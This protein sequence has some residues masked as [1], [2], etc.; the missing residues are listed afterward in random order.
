MKHIPLGSS[1][2][3]VSELCIGSMTWGRQNIQEE[4]FAQ[5]DR[6][7]DYGINFVDTAEMYPVMPIEAETVGGSEEII[8]NWCAKTGRRKDLVI[9]TKITGPNGGFVR[10]GKGIFPET[11]RA[12]VE[13]SLARLQSD[14]IDLYQ[15]HWPN[16]GSYHF[17]QH[18]NYDPSKQDV[19]GELQNIADLAGVLTEL[20]DAGKIRAFGLSND[21]SW[22]TMQWVKA[23]DAAGGPR[24]VTMQNEYS[25]LCRYFDTDMGEICHHEDITLIAYS[26]LATGLLTGKY[27][28]GA[29]PEGS[30]MSRVKNLSGRSTER[31][32]AATKAYKNIADKHGISLIHLALAFVRA[33]PFRAIPI[34]GATSLEQLEAVFGAEDVEMTDEIM[35]E[36]NDVHRQYPLPY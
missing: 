19:S 10:D 7:T 14:Y 25:L 30:R 32:H 24:P 33:R 22:G 12:A 8:G 5:L 29:V 21:T 18:W 1:D 3:H 6:A 20:R 16:R 13:A 36:I 26:P 17:R 15:F 31:S 23:S 35:G 27:M 34:F 11:V 2:I 4:A 28:D 9:A